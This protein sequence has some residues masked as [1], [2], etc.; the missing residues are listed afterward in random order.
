M[1]RYLKVKGHNGMVRD[2]TSGAILVKS[3]SEYEANIRA[4]DVV[5]NRN[6]QI[7]HQAEEINNIKDELDSIPKNRKNL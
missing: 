6:D 2:V 1:N 7:Q 4:R 3:D 5:K